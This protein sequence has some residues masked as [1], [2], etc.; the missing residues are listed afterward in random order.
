ML[1]GISGYVKRWA[2]PFARLWLRY[3]FKK[4]EPSP[5]IAGYY[6]PERPV[7][8]DYLASFIEDLNRQGIKN[9]II[10]LRY[11]SG[12]GELGSQLVYH[13]T[14][15]SDLISSKNYCYNPDV[16]ERY[17]PE[18]GRT[19]RLW[20]IEKYGDDP[21]SKELTLIPRDKYDFFLIS[22]IRNHYII[23]RRTA[24]FLPAGS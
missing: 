18:K 19:F 2:R 6:D 24:L 3:Q 17:S 11:N 1:D 4:K 7:F 10:D 21:P 5:L 9:L 15:R 16:F 20:Y 12:G 22:L 13:L 8:K 23:Y 14:R